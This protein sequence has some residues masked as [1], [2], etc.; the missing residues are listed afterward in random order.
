MLN[1]QVFLFRQR[2]VN[3]AE[4]QSLLGIFDAAFTISNSQ[5]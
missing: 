2:R 1:L 5:R 4:Q 3:V